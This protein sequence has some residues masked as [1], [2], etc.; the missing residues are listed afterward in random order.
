MSNIESTKQDI[1]EAVEK[2]LQNF[3]ENAEKFSDP[4]IGQDAEGGTTKLDT[5]YT[6]HDA[7][8]NMATLRPQGGAPAEAGGEEAP[9]AEEEDKKEMKEGY[10]KKSMKKSKKSTE[11]YMSE[12]FD[13][14]EL[15]PEFKEKLSVVFEA[16]LNDRISFVEEEMQNSFNVALNDQ[17]ETLTEELSVKLDE[18]LGYVVEGWT[19]ENKLAIERGIKSDIAESFM[20]GLK[21]LFET[22][23][24]DMPDDKVTVVEELLDAK[25]ELEEELNKQIQMN[26]ELVRESNT[27][28]A[29]SIFVESCEDLTDTQAERFYGLIEDVEF[30]N[31]EQFR[32][33]LSIIKESFFNKTIAAPVTAAKEETPQV[34]S[35][36]ANET[37][38]DG[39]SDPMMEAYVRAINFQNRNRNK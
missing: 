38:H 2:G 10:G 17:V 20:E 25:K 16:A 32:N 39:G 29:K 3:K 19:E 36:D 6:P 5:C 7:S 33:R 35:E 14:D 12:L 1:A 15:T 8:T 27:N 26:V 22:H 30:E 37:S 34:L 11:E 18:F 24:I 31:E 21:T 23:Y 28:L 4:M 13:Q 9:E